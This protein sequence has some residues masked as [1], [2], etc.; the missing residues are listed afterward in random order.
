MKRFM[1]IALLIA[2]STVVQTQ[3][4]D[5]KKDA[6]LLQGDWKMDSLQESEGK[7]P[8]AEMLKDIL[9]TIKGDE[10]KLTMKGDTIDRM[11]LTMDASKNPKTIDFLHLEGPD[12]SKTEFGIYK[13]EGNKLTICV[14]DVGK[15][16]PAAFAIPAGTKTTLMVLS[17][18]K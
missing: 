16:R 15:A 5:T 10:L 1:T 6:E 4:G 11:K 13:I 7:N 14:G 2:I 18:A 8:P 9:V 17:K 3:A 12:K